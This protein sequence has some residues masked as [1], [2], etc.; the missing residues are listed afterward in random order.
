MEVKSR[1]LNEKGTA[2]CVRYR[3]GKRLGQ[4]E[5]RLG[6][7]RVS[8]GHGFDLFCGFAAWLSQKI[9]EAQRNGASVLAVDWRRRIG[10][11][12]RPSAPWRGN[13]R[14]GGWGKSPG[15]RVEGRGTISEI[16]AGDAQRLSA[17]GGQ[18]AKVVSIGDQLLK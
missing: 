13:R 5:P 16:V 7:G 9:R 12:A 1:R 10:S 18:A 11:G 17:T 15:G 14:A 6:G 3:E 2:C 4:G 8:D